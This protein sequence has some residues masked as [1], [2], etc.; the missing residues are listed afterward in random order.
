MPLYVGVLHGVAVG[1]SLLSL[2]LQTPEVS[3]AQEWLDEGPPGERNAM[4]DAVPAC[5]RTAASRNPSRPIPVPC[6]S[7]ARPVARA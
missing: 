1:V 2:D 3:L 7:H 6:A 5:H 4:S